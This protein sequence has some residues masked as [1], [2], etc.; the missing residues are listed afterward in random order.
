MLVF[1]SKN[2][3]LIFSSRVSRIQAPILV[4]Q[5]QHFSW[6]DLFVAKDNNWLQLDFDGLSYPI[7]I[8]EAK[9]INKPTDSSGVVL[10]SKG[11]PTT[12]FSIK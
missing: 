12:W 8:S 2:K 6:Q 3:G 9:N 5:T 11:R 4:A 10:F 1:E 7:R